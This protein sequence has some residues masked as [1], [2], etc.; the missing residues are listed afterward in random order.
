MCRRAN[1][2]DLDKMLRILLSL[3]QD[4]LPRPM[5]LSDLRTHYGS[6]Q[7]TNL[8]SAGHDFPRE[9]DL[10]VGKEDADRDSDFRRGLYE[11]RLSPLT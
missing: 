7:K 6:S 1:V 3:T 10:L 11:Q 4:A 9:C 8:G 5:A 2:M